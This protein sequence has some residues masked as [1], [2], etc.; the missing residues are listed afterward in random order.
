[1]GE[2]G[3]QKLVFGRKSEELSQDT[4]RES[5]QDVTPYDRSVDR[6]RS[7]GNLAGHGTGL[8]ERGAGQPE[9]MGHFLGT[10]GGRRLGHRGEG[11]REDPYPQAKTGGEL[12]ADVPGRPGEVR[13][14]QADFLVQLS[15]GGGNERAVGVGDMTA[16][17]RDI[18]RSRV[19]G[20]V[21]P[22]DQEGF[23]LARSLPQYDG[24]RRPRRGYGGSQHLEPAEQVREGR[25]RHTHRRNRRRHEAQACQS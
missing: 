24:N 18:A 2:G 14:R 23:D 3:S 8:A 4:T 6:D 11:S 21:R 22:N 7:S 19:V 16:R 5:P 9:Y 20:V 25:G 17:E 12:R 10:A 1:M 13:F 15:Q